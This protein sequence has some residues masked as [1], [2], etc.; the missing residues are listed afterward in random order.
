MQ[1]AQ[2]IAARTHRDG[3]ACRNFIFPRAGIPFS[4]GCV[5]KG[6]ELC[7][8]TAHVSGAAENNRVARVELGE[9]VVVF[10]AA[11]NDVLAAD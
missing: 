5:R 7:C 11:F 6:L 10:V 4:A 1:R 3:E 9:H 8:W 2:L